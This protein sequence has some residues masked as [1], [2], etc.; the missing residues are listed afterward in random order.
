MVPAAY[1]L[2]RDYA[3]FGRMSHVQTYEA[4]G[5]RRTA[6]RILESRRTTTAGGI[7]MLLYSGRAHTF[8]TVADGRT[9][10]ASVSPPVASHGQRMSRVHIRD[11]IR[12]NGFFLWKRPLLRTI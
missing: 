10:E 3:R 4:T 12:S 9:N 7:A 2:A 1:A 5:D 8:C 11:V 6:A